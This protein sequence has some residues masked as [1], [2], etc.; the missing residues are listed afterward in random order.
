MPTVSGARKPL[1]SQVVYMEKRSYRRTTR[2]TR[3]LADTP[4]RK[5][6]KKLI[7]IFE[8][9]GNEKEFWVPR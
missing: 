8:F 4:G 7:S 3:L 6:L 5:R 9:N 1:L 2:A